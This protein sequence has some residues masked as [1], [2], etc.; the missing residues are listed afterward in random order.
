MLS[1]S[2]K[3]LPVKHK[4]FSSAGCFNDIIAR[5]SSADNP[6]SRGPSG[7]SVR[8]ASTKSG[9]VSRLWGQQSNDGTERTSRWS[10]L[11]PAVAT[12]ISLGAPYGWSAISATVAREHGFVTAAGA[13]WSLDLVTYPMSIMIAAGGITAA[14]TGKWTL[15]VAIP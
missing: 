5:I 4:L 13:D 14:L 9:L 11:L 3:G 6:G 10:M 8:C 1:I 15:K 2:A 7:G 12:H